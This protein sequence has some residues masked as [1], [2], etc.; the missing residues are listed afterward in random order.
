MRE[1]KAGNQ[2]WAVF[3]DTVKEM[4]RRSTA[5]AG[6]QTT[7]MRTTGCRVFHPLKSANDPNGIAESESPRPS[8]GPPRGAPRLLP[9]RARRRLL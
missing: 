1:V 2:E 9:G 8:W 7:R 5:W 3:L 4:P 6:A